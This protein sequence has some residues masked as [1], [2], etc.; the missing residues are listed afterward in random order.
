MKANLL[1]L[2]SFLLGFGAVMFVVLHS[3]MSWLDFW[4]GG[5]M[6]ATLQMAIIRELHRA[7]I[8]LRAKAQND[9]P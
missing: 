6:Y 5:A 8:A 1:L 2:T 4:V 9:L 7:S 3:R